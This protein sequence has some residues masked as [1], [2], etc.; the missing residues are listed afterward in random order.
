[1]RMDRERHLGAPPDPA[2]QSVKRLGRHRPAPLRLKTC[3]DGPAYA[4]GAAE[5]VS[6][7]LA[8][9]GHSAT[10]SW[11]WDM[12][13]TRRQ[14]DLR[15]LE[16]AQLGSPETVAVADQDHGCVPMAPAASLPG[17]THEALDLAAREVLASSN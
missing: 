12:Q 14:F 4:V 10:R 1:M 7:H 16:V 15:P 9:D 17:G 11:P 3:E 2:E 13:S 6:R 8:W 5:R